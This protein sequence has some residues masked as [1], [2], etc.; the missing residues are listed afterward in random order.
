MFG[1]IRNSQIITEAEKYARIDFISE[2]LLELE[3]AVKAGD[4]LEQIDALIDIAY[5]AMGTAA[6][7]G[8]NWERHWNE[9]HAANMRKVAGSN[10]KRPDLPYDLVKPEGWMVPDHDKVVQM[11]PKIMVIGHAR[12]GKDTIANL[13][14]KR[15]GFRNK[16]A[17]MI[18]AE[19]II[20]PISLSTIDYNWP[21]YNSFLECFNDKHSHREAWFKT[22]Q[23][24][25]A[26][27]KANLARLVYSESDVYCGVRDAAE[28]WT[29]HEDNRY[30]LCIWVDASERLPLEPSTSITVHQCMADVVI[31]N[32]GTEFALED[33]LRAIMKA[34]N[35]G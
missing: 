30:D 33:S 15:Y 20:Y 14:E 4:D 2:E 5:V 1:V 3:D 35:Y 18:A 12:H 27:D 9:V 7:S 6:L 29:I 10:D 34:Y 16:S 26:S 23:K 28:L 11:S 13:L 22:I 21:N 17:A 31:N 24:F 8:F 25:N 32:N 19:F